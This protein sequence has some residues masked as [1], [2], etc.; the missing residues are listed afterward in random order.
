MGEGDWLK[1]RPIVGDRVEMGRAE[2][3]RGGEGVMVFA[4]HSLEAM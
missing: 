3:G 2:E 1:D 4:V